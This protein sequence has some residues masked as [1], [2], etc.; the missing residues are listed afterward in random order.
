VPLHAPSGNN[1]VRYASREC[2]IAF[3]RADWESFVPSTFIPALHVR[4]HVGASNLRE[5]GAQLRHRQAVLRSGV[6]TAEQERV[7]GHL[8]LV[9]RAPSTSASSESW[10]RC[11][12][13]RS[14]LSAS[15]VPWPRVCRTSTPRRTRV[16]VTPRF[17]GSRRS[18]TARAARGRPVCARYSEG[19]ASRASDSARFTVVIS[20]ASRAGRRRRPAGRRRWRIA[21]RWAA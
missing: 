15:T 18:S 8:R 2:S 9:S 6:H 7:A 17:V 16:R 13:S 4:L 12:R 10:L 19:M 5:H 20:E 11:S 21:R 3:V 14:S 1:G